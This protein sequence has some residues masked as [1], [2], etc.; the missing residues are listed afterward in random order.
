MSTAEV[1]K[2]RSLQKEIIKEKFK[3]LAN[4]ARSCKLTITELLSNCP[5]K[6]YSRITELLLLS[7]YTLELIENFIGIEF[8]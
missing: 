6:I 1:E 8:F 4:L 7:P 5:K 3:N 2:E